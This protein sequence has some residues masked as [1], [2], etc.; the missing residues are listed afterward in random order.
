MAEIFLADWGRRILALAFSVL[1]GTL[2]LGVVHMGGSYPQATWDSALG[3]NNKA[4]R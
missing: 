3:V 1:P 4:R 2:G